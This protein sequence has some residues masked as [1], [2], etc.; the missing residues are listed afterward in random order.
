MKSADFVVGTGKQKLGVMRAG[1]L[2]RA[3]SATFAAMTPLVIS[4]ND[5][6]IF[7]QD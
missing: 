1:C 2:R 6:D 7:T 5:R 4:D 3:R